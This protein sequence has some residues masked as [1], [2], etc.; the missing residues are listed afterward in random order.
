MTDV[1]L[2]WLLGRVTAPI[3]GMTKLEQ[4]DGAVRAL[5]VKLTPEEAAYLEDPYIPH[6]LVGI[7]ATNK[8]SN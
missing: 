2:A 3:V 8:G 7:R 6:S 1:A 4:V 5:Q